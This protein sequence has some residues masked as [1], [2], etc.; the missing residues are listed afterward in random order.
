MPVDVSL[1]ADK[2]A[3]MNGIE[4]AI[5]P[6]RASVKSVLMVRVYHAAV[7]KANSYQ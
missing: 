2:L 3:K 5:P 7:K 1:P 6:D 4:K